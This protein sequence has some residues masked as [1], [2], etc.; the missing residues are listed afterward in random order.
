TR[1]RPRTCLPQNITITA[2]QTL[3][4]LEEIVEQII[5]AIFGVLE[6]TPPELASDIS[7]RG[8]VMTGG[9]SLLKG[10]D[11]LISQKTG[12]PVFIAEDAISCVALGAGKALENLDKLGPNSIYSK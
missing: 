2:A 3:D 5:N 1:L 7:E 4:A 9:G 12:I 6:K 10:M 11:K 8:I